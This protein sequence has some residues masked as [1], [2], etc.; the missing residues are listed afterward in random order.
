MAHLDGV[1]GEVVVQD[2]IVHITEH[3]IS[4]VPVAVETQ[5]VSVVVEKLL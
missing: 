4:V 2:H 1:V 5:H 3:F